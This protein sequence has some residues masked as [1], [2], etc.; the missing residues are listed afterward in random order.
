MSVA[1][2]QFYTRPELAD[3]YVAQVL[4]RW[5]DPDVLFVEPSAGTGAFVR[6]LLN[7]G[8]T[9][10]ALDIDPQDPRIIKSDFLQFDLGAYK[11][12]HSAIVVVGNPPFGKNACT[13]VRFFN[14][15]A[16]H[17]DEIAFIVPRTFRKMS[18]QKRLHGMFHLSE[19]GDVADRA[20]IRFGNP[21]DVPCAWQVWTKRDV[22]RPMPVPPPVDHLIGY[23]TPRKADFAMRR[24]G[25]YAGRIVTANI[26][27]LSQTTHYFIQEMADGVIDSLRKVNW[28]ELASQTAGVRSISKTEIAFKLNE[29]YHV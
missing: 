14:R 26:R 18:L 28:S 3:A 8:K 17:A 21:H 27:S 25:F 29:V 20:F 13:A 4:E 12:V 1:L 7:A 2:D 9:V 23:T 5:S 11:H 6:P 15:A 10:C 16:R 24:V 22:E 19:D